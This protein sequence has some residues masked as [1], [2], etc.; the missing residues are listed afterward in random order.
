MFAQIR[1]A[2]IGDQ[3]L[4]RGYLQDCLRELSA[5]GEVEETYEY[6]DDYW[7]EPTRWPYVI[8]VDGGPIGFIFVNQWSPSG[9]GTDYAVAEFYVAPRWRGQG[10][11][12]QAA[13]QV[14]QEHPGQWELH[15][16]SANVAAESFWP[17]VIKK[18]GTASYER[19]AGPD[20][21]IL[22]FLIA[23]RDTPSK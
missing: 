22:R 17:A 23:V 6:F 2:E 5:F 13:R 9:R 4:V 14:F 12:M 8:E 19:V 3:S 15:Y 7:T 1:K 11:G 18:A 16:F 10:H 20:T 21:T